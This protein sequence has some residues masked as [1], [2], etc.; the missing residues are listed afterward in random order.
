MRIVFWQNLLAFYQ[1]PHIQALAEMGHSVVWVSQEEVS[2]ERRAQGWSIPNYSNMNVCLAPSDEEIKRLIQEAGPEAIH[3]FSGLHGFP[4]VTK[5]FHECLKTSAR[6]GLLIENRDD[7]G[8]KGLMRL[9]QYRLDHLRYGK[10]ISFILSM[11]YTGGHGGR[12][13]YRRCGF[14]EEAIFPYGYFV[15][16]PKEQIVPVADP[17][18]TVELLFV[19]QLVQ[20]KGVDVLLKALAPHSQLKWRL[21]VLGD[22]SEKQTLMDLAKSLGIAEHV[23]FLPYMKNAE[24]MN[25]MAQSDL[26]ILPSRFD[27]WGVV[28]NEALLRGVPVICSDRCGAQDL[29]QEEWRGEVFPS[30]SVSDLSRILEK[31]IRKGKNTP[32]SAARINDWNR[33]ISGETAAKY[34]C[35]VLANVEGKG[36]RPTPPWFPGQAQGQSSARRESVL[37]G[38]TGR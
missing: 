38:S 25:Q 11:G 9:M 22:G 29:L 19:G 34:L 4:M 27:G 6:L 17:N 33:S 36:P 15:G 1:A 7:R 12:Y 21:R 28:I 20:R 23:E 14:G 35:E 18:E 32:E 5:A 2:E 3:V 8:L 37:A 24:A 31:W 13:W 26:F 10:R 30:E 16:G